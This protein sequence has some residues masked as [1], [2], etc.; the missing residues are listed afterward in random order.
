[1]IIIARY[2]VIREM[3]SIS[4]SFGKVKVGKSD[5]ELEVELVGDSGGEGDATLSTLG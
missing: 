3:M 1:M 2:S 4:P 5:V